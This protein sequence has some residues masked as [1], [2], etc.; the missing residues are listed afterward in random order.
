MMPSRVSC[1]PGV[2]RLAV[3]LFLSKPKARGFVFI[4]ISAQEAGKGEDK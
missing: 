2:L 4:E 3:L 1:V